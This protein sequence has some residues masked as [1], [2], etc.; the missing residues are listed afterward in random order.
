MM[1]AFYVTHDAAKG[2]AVAILVILACLTWY[3]A[4]PYTDLDIELPFA[5]MYSIP[6]CKDINEHV[7]IKLDMENM[8][9]L[10]VEL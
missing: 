9:N 4:G 5:A 1:G 6:T 10:K 7:Y 3:A 2:S 8:H